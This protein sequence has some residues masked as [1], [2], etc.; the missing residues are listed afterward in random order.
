MK[1][2]RIIKHFKI[3]G[4]MESDYIVDLAKIIACKIYDEEK[5]N[6]GFFQI[7]IWIIKII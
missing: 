4:S 2:Q 6:R 5:K 1:F 7:S 3:F